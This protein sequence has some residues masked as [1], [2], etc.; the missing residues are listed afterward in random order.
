MLERERERERERETGTPPKKKFSPEKQV[1][2][3]RS[4]WYHQQLALSEKKN[5][6][7]RFFCLEIC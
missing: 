5:Q 3:Q 4:R 6:F 7:R 1:P 2:N